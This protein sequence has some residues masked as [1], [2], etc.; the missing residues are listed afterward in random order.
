MK[1]IIKLFDKAVQLHLHAER[2]RNNTCYISE[3][4]EQRYEE[5]MF[6]A[7]EAENKLFAAIRELK[8]KK[9]QVKPKQAKQPQVWPYP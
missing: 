1:K 7:H 3:K 4:Q 8:Q 6:E 5:V 2:E 9:K